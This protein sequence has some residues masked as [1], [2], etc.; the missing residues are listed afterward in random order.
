MTRKRIYEIM[1]VASPGDKTSRAFDI[2]ILSLIS[3]NVLFLVAETVENIY[4]ISPLFFDNFELLSIII[5]TLEYFLRIWCCIENPAYKKPILGR[6][7]YAISIY[8]LIDLLVIL[9]YLL[10][11]LP[12]DYRFLR[13]IRLIRLLRIL[14]LARYSIAMGSLHSVIKR[15]KEELISTLIVLLILLL[16]AAS[17]MYILE[18][19]VQPEAFSSIPMTMWW[20]IATL[21]TVGYGDVYPIT[22]AGK[23]LGAVIALLGIGLFALPAGL[24]GG[25]FLEEIEERKKKNKTSKNPNTSVSIN[26]NESVNSRHLIADI[27]LDN[28]LEDKNVDFVCELIRSNFK[29]LKEFDHEYTPYGLTKGFILSESHSFIHTYP[30]HNF[31]C[32]DVFVCSPG[33][34]L[35]QFVGKIQQGL[36]IRKIQYQI[37]KRG[38]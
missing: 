9:P 7:K 25:S 31:I 30:E 16:Y 32:I 38:I 8:A 19:E 1:E 24:I 13:A 14:K 29:V 6:F 15:R 36:K 21:T 34:D 17:A 27:W 18:H 26:E 35:N 20:G 22:G 23:V 28:E 2:F 12:G 33:V 4:K 37:L 10:I 3:I 5:F 11:F